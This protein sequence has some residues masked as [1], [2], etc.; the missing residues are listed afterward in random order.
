[1][2]NRFFKH[3]DDGSSKAGPP[4]HRS[5]QPGQSAE[6]LTGG[7]FFNLPPLVA[8]PYGSA[9]PAPVGMGGGA[10]IVPGGGAS[11]GVPPPT[12]GR[13]AYPQQPSYGN[14]SSSSYEAPV[15]NGASLGG[16]DMFGG[17]SMKALPAA[18]SSGYPSAQGYG[19]P[20]YGGSGAA[21]LPQPIT[22]ASAVTGGSLFSGLD[23][24]PGGS[25]EES[26]QQPP[27]QHS[28]AVVDRRK[29]GT[30]TTGSFNYLDVT[31]ASATTLTETRTASSS[32]GSARSVGKVVKKKKTKSFRPGFGRQ[33]SDES[34]AALQ[35]GDLKEEDV[36]QG[37]DDN[38]SSTASA[39]PSIPRAPINPTDLEHLLP[40]VVGGSVLLGLTVHQTSAST[41]GSSSV[42]AGLTVHSATP[43]TS[44]PR[45]S[46][47][48]EASSESK[49]GGG[50]LAG[51]NV[52]KRQGSSSS[53]KREDSNTSVVTSRDSAP[54]P[55]A[56]V[57]VGE[58]QPVVPAAPPTPEERLL[59]TL[60]DFHASAVS[61]R[62]NVLKQND[63]ENRILERKV[64][65][66]N[67]LTQYEIDLRDV[68]A[69]QHHACEVEDFERA[70]ALNA[71]I[72]SVRHCITLTESDVRKV[73]SELAAFV[74][75]KE[76]AFANQLRSTRGTLR[77]LEKFRDDQEAERVS[78]RNEFKEYEVKETEQ[79]QFEAERIDTEMHHV[80]VNLDHLT[81][82][83]SEIEATIEE[84]CRD[85]FAVQAQLL[86]E[87]AHVEEE[88]RELERKLKLKLERVREIQESIQKAEKDIDVVR[89]RYSRQL[90]RI[91]DRESGILK[92]K[93]EV[94]SDVEQLKNQKR[95]FHD[96]LQE[97]ETNIATF[98]KRILT[99]RKEMR[100]ASLLA[101]VL[102]V[103]ETRREQSL[104]R[105][106]Q[107]T[108][109]L[110]SL[111]DAAAIA[112]Q[113]FV[114]LR[115][116]HDELEKSLSIHRNA[117]ASAESMIPRLE[118]EKKTAATQRNFKDAARISKDIKALE[119]DR[120]TAEEMVEVVEM[121]LQD[122]KERIDKREVEYEEKKDELKKVEKQL[123]LTTLQELWKE[124]RHLRVSIRK[125]EKF[126][127][128]GTAA[129]NG[130]DFRSSALL[131]VQAEFDACMIQ[132]EALEHKY[133]VSDPNKNQE[134]DA[135]D[136]DDD[137]EELFDEEEEEH[138]LVRNSVVMS[139]IGGSGS[140][141]A[142]GVDATGDA[143]EV[144]LD[145]I[146]DGSSALEDIASKLSEL[147][148]MI[149]KATENEEYELA[150]RLDEKIEVLKRRQHSIA[151]LSTRDGSAENGADGDQVESEDEEEE[152]DRYQE[153]EQYETDEE[154][155]PAAPTNHGVS[156]HQHDAHEAAGHDDQTVE[157][158]EEELEALRER[159]IQ[160]ED[161]IDLAT[162]NE[163]YENAA[164][165]DEELQELRA[166][167]EEI[168][169]LLSTATATTTGEQLQQHQNS[170]ASLFMGLGVK[171]PS[172][173]KIDTTTTPNSSAMTPPTPASSMFGGLE[174]NN[175]SRRLSGGSANTNSSATEG[176]SLFG[177]LEMSGAGGAALGSMSPRKLSKPPSPIE[178]A[179]Q[180][181]SA[182]VSVVATTNAAVDSP[183]SYSL[184]AKDSFFGGLT[185]GGKTNSMTASPPQPPMSSTSIFGSL[186]LS[187][188]Q[189]PA[190]SS[191]S[192]TTD[193]QEA[194]GQSVFSGLTISQTAVENT[195]GVSHLHEEEEKVTAEETPLASKSVLSTDS[196]NAMF[197]GLQVTVP[198]PGAGAGADENASKSEVHSRTGSS[199][200]LI[201]DEHSTD[202]PMTIHELSDH[203][204]TTDDEEG[205]LTSSI[206]GGGAG[207]V[208][209]ESSF[210]DISFTSTSHLNLSTAV[211][212][213]MTT[214]SASTVVASDSLFGGLSLMQPS[215]SSATTTTT[216]A[217]TVAV[218]THHAAVEDDD[219]TFDDAKQEPTE[220]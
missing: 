208:S 1:M 218:E 115:K 182:D 105:K 10:P 5:S 145:A 134:D 99:V 92:T 73:D 97:Y 129:D 34:I 89:N 75:S 191:H 19:A 112:E 148:E 203:N 88:V 172:I 91:A 16:G 83:K 161:D 21:S 212:S 29:S 45:S 166:E 126:K 66:A 168:E 77:E 62:E 217:T 2:F 63:E 184:G 93:S 114:M 12:Y 135:D 173:E 111:S 101:G 43:S 40:P 211:T 47:K 165:F 149:E 131:L 98:G 80:S 132:V 169:H 18:A 27:P 46:L 48:K 84:Q 55:G 9:S 15:G 181:Q 153:A 216:T 108:A 28:S 37:A 143:G 139:H 127:S 158:L 215:S 155:A 174:V 179:V 32:A 159:I 103:Q 122:L 156:Y 22:A 194:A 185:V 160:V 86:E 107:Q 199:S 67:Q 150:A 138:H 186:Q 109:E 59:N 142:S 79:L 146:G 110:S 74:K 163:E 64:Q 17:M 124:G 11:G 3:K 180:L 123:E 144:D 201:E 177:G 65:L 38:G 154:T 42:L 200:S 58:P 152:E 35:R 72:N 133:G 140:G 157:E 95:E 36:I 57:V 44:S 54:S 136:D 125:M 206:G 20:A 85:E 137:D 113:S 50:V 187:S 141:A 210:T 102:E 23:L 104:V 70:D 167:Q 82:E 71:T 147:E 128:D 30:R 56:A 205:S 78:M 178:V 120:S 41:S 33:L 197:A 198:S 121:E 100:A 207:I 130:V 13:P 219:D 49:N 52:H 188:L 31:A 209:H 117:I 87:K 106:K 176:S 195:N 116:Q 60:R 7:G 118:Q 76:K 53:L 26:Q 162:Q 164:A 8:K 4:G 202:S 39:T 68:E 190:H 189:S 24:A 69:Q 51:L 220:L 193:H 175:S 81:T 14:S 192:T 119:K 170:S 6:E 214:T 96:K 90:K 151:A 204:L 171:Q 196:S 94:E 25:Y 183:T 213:T 61:F